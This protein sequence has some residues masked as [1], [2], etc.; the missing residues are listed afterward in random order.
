MRSHLIIYCNCHLLQEILTIL[1]KL[2]SDDSNHYLFIAITIIANN[3][4]NLKITEAK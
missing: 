4:D 1:Y 3:S 2:L